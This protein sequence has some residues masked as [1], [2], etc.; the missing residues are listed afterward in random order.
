MYLSN[1]NGLHSVHVLTGKHVV[2]TKHF[3][4]DERHFVF[5]PDNKV[6]V[7]IDTLSTHN[8]ITSDY[9]S[10]N[11]K[12]NNNVRPAVHKTQNDQKEILKIEGTVVHKGERKYE[13]RLRT[14]AGKY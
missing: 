9:S 10:V 12:R 8:L 13:H 3:S 11:V 7:D 4:F 5:A 6:Y 1:D 14:G 2:E